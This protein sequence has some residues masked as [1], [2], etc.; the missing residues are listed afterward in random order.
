MQKIKENTH[1]MLRWSEQ[2]TKTDMVYLAR[3]GFWLTFSQIIVSFAS[4]LLAIAFANYVSKETYGQYKYILSLAGILG[5]FTL[6]GLGSAVMRSVSQGFEGTLAY[7]FWQNIK[8][9]AGFFVGSFAISTYYFIHGNTTL[10]VSMLVI[11]SL[12]PFFASTN[13]Y[14]AFLTAKKDFRRNAIYFDIIGNI[15]PYTCLLITM[16]VTDKP[17]WLVAT[18]FASNTLIGVFLYLRVVRIYK[19]NREVDLGLLGYSKHL[20]L[21]NVLGNIA[22]NIDQVLIFHY[23][24]AVELAIYNFATA[25]PNQTKG[26]LRGISSLMFPKFVERSDKEI[27]ASMTHKFVL[28]FVFGLVLAIT[29][30][31]A[32]PYIFHIFFPKY[33][34]SIIYSQIFA[35]SLISIVSA[36]ADTYLKAKK[37]IKEQY[38]GNITTSIIQIILI[39]GGIA[40]WGLIG[41]VIARVAIRL[42]STVL[43]ISLY[44]YSINRITSSQW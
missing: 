13:L 24:G 33:S 11:G 36:P 25:I 34:A 26:P 12:S 21:I 2:Y 1:K 38:I 32:A 39:C 7:A 27:K 41:L 40:F 29:Y 4:F 31:I 17:V 28:L 30:I 16:M 5:T 14:G 44:Q 42:I 20:S 8:W 22:G 10:G 19:P 35:L 18:Y 3:G 37:K 6:T 43:N 9:S 15:F 23:I